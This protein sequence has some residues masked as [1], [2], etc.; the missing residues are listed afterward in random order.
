M[1]KRNPIRD[2]A[3]FP[4]TRIGHW[5]GQTIACCEEHAEQIANVGKAMGY[6]ISF[7]EAPEGSFCA[8][9]VNESKELSD[10]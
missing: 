6:K 2:D 8:N 10:G 5:P 4:A 7:T 3:R 9:C 1:D